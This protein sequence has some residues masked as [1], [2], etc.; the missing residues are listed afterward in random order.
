MTA[1]QA[2]L[3]PL[4][5]TLYLVKPSGVNSKAKEMVKRGITVLESYDTHRNTLWL[6]LACAAQLGVHV[7]Q[8]RLEGIV[9]LPLVLFRNQSLE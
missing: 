5:R 4:L 8:P 6:R 2:S 7:V 1:N 9:T 3:V